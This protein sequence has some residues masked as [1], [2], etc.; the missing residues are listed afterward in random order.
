MTERRRTSAEGPALDRDLFFRQM[1][2]D[3]AGTLQDVVG[4][5]E[6]KGFI[7]VVGAHMGDRLNTLYREHL[8][9]SVLDREELAP[10]L[11]DLKSRIGG[12]FYVIEETETAIVLGNR[13][14]PFGESVAGRP[15]L[16]MMTSNVFGRIAAENLGYAR[17]SIERA[18]ANGDEGCRVVIRLTPGDQADPAGIEY[19]GSDGDD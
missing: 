15:S 18:I 9:Q 6:S 10:T 7:A 14:C 3:L 11:V 2:R 8:G 1:I 12:D 17:V 16:C 19:F 5:D 4:P 13:R